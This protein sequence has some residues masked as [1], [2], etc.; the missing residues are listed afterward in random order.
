MDKRIIDFFKAEN[1]EY[2]AALKYSDAVELN[3]RLRERAGVDAKSI[4]LFLL[5]YYTADGENLSRYA[6][7]LDYHLVIKKITSKLSA[8]LGEIF[9]GCS[10]VGFGDHSPID[11]RGAALSSGLGILGDNGLLI[12]E[13][14]GSYVFIADVITDIPAEVLGAMK[15]L[16]VSRCE[17]C[18]LCKKSCPTGI[19]RGEG[20]ECL[21][22][23]TQKKGELSETEVKMMLEYNTVWGCDLC[24]SSCP[25]N[26]KPNK[27]PIEFFYDSAIT[28]LSSEILDSMDE[29][30][31]SKR[32]YAWRG[33]K[34]IKRN[35]EYY[36]STK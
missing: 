6:V 5:P 30:E 20:T 17:G 13:K 32:A 1:I 19:L 29:D 24:Q 33:K 16:P 28:M 10:A 34:T 31:F 25:H 18:G 23:I 12:N 4:I 14:Y 26:H 7:S 9:P 27:T 36:E 3:P 22:A 11:E 2:Y 15:P 21:S 8:L 35:L